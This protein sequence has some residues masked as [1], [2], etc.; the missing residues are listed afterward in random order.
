MPIASGSSDSKSVKGFSEGQDQKWQAKLSFLEA[1]EAKLSKEQW[2]TSC[3]LDSE[4]QVSVAALS[5]DR[6]N[7]SRRFSESQ[8]VGSDSEDKSSIIVN[9]KRTSLLSIVR[10]KAFSWTR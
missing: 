10:R 7:L 1:A 9:E 3:Y 4:R 2:R 5:S 8:A 6:A